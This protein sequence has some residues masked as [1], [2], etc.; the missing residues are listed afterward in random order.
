MGYLPMQCA[1]NAQCT[2]DALRLQ[3]LKR[4]WEQTPF[5]VSK[6]TFLYPYMTAFGLDQAVFVIFT[7]T[8]NK[9]DKWIITDGK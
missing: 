8:T 3:T 5:P 7:S 1:W 9:V 4:K 2:L 6:E